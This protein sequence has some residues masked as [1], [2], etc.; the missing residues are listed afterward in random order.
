MHVFGQK[1][2]KQTG[3][4][5]GNN[6][7]KTPVLELKNIA[8]TFVKNSLFNKNKVEVLKDASLTL[9]EGES[10]ALIGPSGCGKT[11]LIKMILGLEKQDKGQIK[12]LG[13]DTS[14]MTAK[15]FKKALLKIGV[16]FQDPFS[17]LDPKQTI[18]QIL[19]EPFLIHKKFFTRQTLEQALKEV[20]LKE[21]DLKKYPHQFSGGQCQR[22]NI[23]RALISKP[24]LIIADEPTSALDVSVQAQIINLLTKMREKYNFSLL[25][26]SH[27]L[28][29]CKYLCQN[30]VLV[31]QGT[32]NK[33]TGD[34]L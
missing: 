25:F 5:M 9:C 22:I 34:E 27:N 30:I 18:E 23:A 24:K 16:I 19:S 10:L 2:L 28:A 3:G 31:R 12:I 6:Q 26:I 4:K 17:A 32:L 13:K 15:E 8:K 20:S 33:I 14:Q 11:T 1:T 7:N 21:T 29:L